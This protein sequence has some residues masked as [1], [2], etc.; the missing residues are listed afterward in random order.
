MG[1]I[2]QI[3][4]VE[5]PKSSRKAETDISSGANESARDKPIVTIKIENQDKNM[6]FDTGC[7]CNVIDFTF[8]KH[9]QKSTQS[10][11]FCQKSMICHLQ[12]EQGCL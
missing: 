11:K 8:L 7:D 1:T 2:H 9:Y 3:D 4:K 5:K 12:M 10:L 6:L